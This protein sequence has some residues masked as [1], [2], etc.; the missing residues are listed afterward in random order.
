MNKLML[1]AMIGVAAQ[2]T[3]AADAHADGFKASSL[4]VYAADPAD[5]A[6]VKNGR[7]QKKR[8]NESQE[9]A[10]VRMLDKTSGIYVQ[11][12]S[13]SLTD[14]T[15]GAKTTPVHRQQLAVTPFKL[16]QN[17]DGSVGAQVTGPSKFITD[18]VGQDYRN[19]NQPKTYAINGGKN[20][21]VTFNYRPQGANNTNRY[22]KVIDAQGNIVPVQDA[23]GQT[24][25]QV[26]IMAK[27]NDDCDMSQASGA[28]QVVADDPVAGAHIVYWAG[29][30][31]N[32]KDDGWV[33]DIQV[34][35]VN[36]GA[37]FQIAKNFDVDVEPQEERTRGN[38]TV[39][40]ADPNTAICTWTAGNN[41]P[42]REGTWVG[43]IDITP[44]GPKGQNANS[45]LLWKK[46]IQNQT[47]YQGVRTYS[48][49]ANSAR[50]H[51]TDASGNLVA[52]D[53]L[54][55]QTSLLR[56]NNTNNRKGGRYLGI[57]MGVA[58]A[59]KTGLTWD[60]PLTDVT[61][62]MLGIDATH[63]TEVSALVQDGSKLVP[64]MTFLQGSQNGGGA[65]PADLKVL[66]ADLTAKKFVDYG[67]H[68]AGA[69]YDRHLY[70]NYLGG[71]PGNQGRNFAGAELVANPFY[72]AG[73]T[74]A[75]FLVMHALTG[76]DPTDVMNPAIKTSGYISLVAMQ[77]PQA[78]PPPPAG[79]PNTTNVGQNSSGGGQNAQPQAGDP[80]PANQLPGDPGTPGTP[81]TNGS[82]SSGCSM[83]STADASA[84]G[85]FFLLL[86]VGLVTLAR[87]RRA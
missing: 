39:A 5:L 36:N 45:R 79:M 82:F 23:N 29:C 80:T 68:A 61:N 63:L 70:A 48:V 49:R 74:A 11:M 12:Q 73:S 9:Q 26:L 76:K 56:G 37:A 57:F 27:N 72:T 77:N 13:G 55:I 4:K 46:L 22:A 18:N 10:M 17:A 58:T 59:T 86:G 41:Q 34:K 47:V 19:A 44:S 53:K 24:Q 6:P 78:A 16:V 40:A 50:V 65:A 71:N 35:P 60:I 15:T 33:N 52:S 62:Q 69:P 21:L 30:N 38:C 66:A 51:T 42:Q 67:T 25:K 85:V 28:G 2:M 83:A 75:P 3:L 8:Y 54:F 31:G 14:A 1:A 84:S 32:G 81:G 64:A 20:L 7:L 43:A 87:R